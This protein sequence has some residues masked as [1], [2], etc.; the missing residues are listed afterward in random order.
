MT[1]SGQSMTSFSSMLDHTLDEAFE[2][3]G[4]AESNSCKNS[5][6]SRSCPADAQ[7]LLAA[8]GLCN[9]SLGA[10]LLQLQQS[11]G[12]RLLK[13]GVHTDASALSAAVVS[14]IAQ[15]RMVA[16]H[17]N[18]H[19]AAHSTAYAALELAAASF[20]HEGSGRCGS[21]FGVLVVPGT[22]H[23]HIH[24]V[25][26]VAPEAE[27]AAAAASSHGR[28]VRM[29]ASMGVSGFGAAFYGLQPADSR[30][31]SHKAGADYAATSLLQHVHAQDAFLCVL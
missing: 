29:D 23:E 4:V 5:S 11:R 10:A 27:A 3:V 6:S 1:G 2:A 31:S 19:V 22:G 15:G 13:V 17:V 24:A 7:Q 8:A 16:L 18:G 28:R 14:Q 26:H 21:G 20:S 30:G 9:T 25:T 12:L